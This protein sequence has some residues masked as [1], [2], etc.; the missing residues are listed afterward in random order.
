MSTKLLHI[1]NNQEEENYLVHPKKFLVWL[2]MGSIIMMFGAF[3]S[4]YIV[5]KGEGNWLDFDLPSAFNYSTIIIILSSITYHLSY[6]KAKKDEIASLKLNLILTIVLGVAFLIAQWYSWVELYSYKGLNGFG[7]VLGG[8]YS[9]PSGSFLYIIS[10]LHG[11]H[12]ISGLIFLIIV[13][14]MTMKGEV[15]SKSMLWSEACGTYWHF[16]GGLWIVLYVFLIMN[17]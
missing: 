12:I 8:E 13:L 10:G 14:V 9:N 11:F 5:R 17:H 1:M 2:F 4:A 15:N 6:L 16:L 7:I 3:M